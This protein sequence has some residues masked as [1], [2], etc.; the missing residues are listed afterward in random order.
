MG[1]GND[2]EVHFINSTTAMQGGFRNRAEDVD[3]RDQ[4]RIEL[5]N[6]RYKSDAALDVH[7]KNDGPVGDI[8]ASHVHRDLER[9]D[10]DSDW[11]ATS[12]KVLRP[13]DHSF[14]FTQRKRI[15]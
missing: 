3:P 4:L 13:K 9:L 12:N 5:F 1:L 6:T 8:L 14:C 10:K 11:K 7:A 2:Q 15:F